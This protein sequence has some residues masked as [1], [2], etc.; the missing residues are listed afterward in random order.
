MKN[1]TK[2]N[3]TYF[4]FSNIKKLTGVAHGIFTRTGGHSNAPYKSLNISFN[5]GDDPDNVRN[6]IGLITS[7]MGFTAFQPLKQTHSSTIHPINSASHDTLIGDALITSQSN[8]LLIIKTAD[9]QPVLLADPVNHRVAA[10]HSGWR[11]SV[12]NIIGKTITQMV[13]L[14]TKPHHIIA[15]IGPSLGPCCAEFIHYQQ[16]LPEYMWSYAVKPNYFNFWKISKLQLLD[17][18]VLK[19]NIEISNMCTK[20]CKDLFYSYRRNKISGRFA[21][22]IGIKLK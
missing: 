18:G 8:I 7:I 14:G 9:C 5:V 3:L 20:C 21:S 17:K 4:Q 15:G 22:V 13:D 2:D 6:N 19:K 16:E 11:G 1:N 12:Q 10:I